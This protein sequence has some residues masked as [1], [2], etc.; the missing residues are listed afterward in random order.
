MN[1][2]T[3]QID[4]WD[5][6]DTDSSRSFHISNCAEL[7]S[8]EIGRFSFSDYAGGFE[9]RNLPSLTSIKIGSI[10]D[11]HSESNNGGRSFNFYHCSFVIKGIIDIDIANE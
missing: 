9:L 1:S 7:E 10:E 5:T 8:I 3:Q 4:N 11:D 6:I 2:F